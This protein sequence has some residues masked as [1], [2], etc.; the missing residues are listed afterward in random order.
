MKTQRKT[1]DQIIEAQ[2]EEIFKL[3]AAKQELE[4]RLS[5]LQADLD[6]IHPIGKSLGLKINRLVI[7]CRRIAQAARTK[8]A[9]LLAS[10][11]ERLRMLADESGKRLRL[12]A[13]L[14]KSATMV[15]VRGHV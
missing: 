11:R 13:T 1:K 10:I 5:A 7:A 3:D 12:S 8:A 9:A 6:E 14:F 15:I 2:K 4:N